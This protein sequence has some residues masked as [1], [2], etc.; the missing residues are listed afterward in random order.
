MTFDR[1][2]HFYHQLNRNVGKFFPG[3]LIFITIISGIGTYFLINLSNLSEYKIAIFAVLSLDLFLVLLILV[4]VLRRVVQLWSQGRDGLAGSGLHIRLSLL[5]ALVSIFPAIVAFFAMFFFNL[6][7]EN[8]FLKVLSHTVND[9]L[10]IA[11]EYLEEHK[12]QL[13]GDIYDLRENL[14]RV[15]HH[16]ITPQDLG[17]FLSHQI[18]LRGLTEGILITEKSK[19]LARGDFT[20]SIEFDK[21]PEDQWQK[22]RKG[23]VAIFVN[24]DQSRVRALLRTSGGE[25]LYLGRY[26]FPKTIDRIQRIEKGVEDFNHQTE[27]RFTL[28]ISFFLAYMIVS[29]LLVLLAMW[30]GLMFSG[31]LSKPIRKLIVAAEKIRSGDVQTLVEVDENHRELGILARAFNRMLEKI[32]V[33]SQELMQRNIVLNDQN[34]FITAVL[35]GVT[36]GVISVDENGV[37]ELMNP[38]AEKILEIKFA[39]VHGKKIADVFPFFVPLFEE[40]VQVDFMTLSTNVLFDRKSYAISLAVRI[41]KDIEQLHTKY[42]FTFDNISELISAQRKAAWSDVAR[43]I[44]HEIKNPLTPIQL[45]AERVKRKYSAQITTDKEIF[46]NCIS[47]IVHHVEQI[48]QMVD[49]FANFAKMPS[50][51]LEEQNICL[52]VTRIVDLQQ[53]AHPDVEYIWNPDQEHKLMLDKNLF[54]QALTNLLL[55]A[56]ES[57][58]NGFKRKPCIRLSL[59][60]NDENLI[61]SIEDNGK[62]LPKENR[63]KLTE[64][65]ITTRIKGTGLGLAIVKHIM[66]EHKGALNLG[67]SSDLKG[68]KIELIFPI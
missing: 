30:V 64:P 7:L 27:G 12:T 23:D 57:F 39:D 48:G 4:M 55:N 26:V 66:E 36:A 21:I 45:S 13:K 19:V 17:N 31:Y 29:I 61:L 60:Q 15:A 2:L 41:S 54:S 28:Q 52:I 63:E 11:N 58:E 53:L 25:Y 51:K 65:Y 8:Q 67:D 43:R 35:Q 44:A 20:F 3:F 14:E 16:L 62:G 24:Q 38:S 22:A 37:I 40:A 49:E 50:A 32:A 1:A 33:Q 47:T 34:N 56:V 18:A 46:E 9:S 42:I 59:I 5:F 68:A 10:I 6:G